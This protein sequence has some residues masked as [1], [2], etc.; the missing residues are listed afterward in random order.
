MGAH[1]GRRVMMTANAARVVVGTDVQPITS[2]DS[3]A[4]RQVAQ[5]NVNRTYTGALRNG[6]SIMRA[7]KPMESSM[8]LEPITLAYIL[9]VNS[10]SGTQNKRGLTEVAE[11]VVNGRSMN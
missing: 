1:V 7:R 10:L 3:I 6:T 5:G 11:T 4:A 8:T 9:T 2:L